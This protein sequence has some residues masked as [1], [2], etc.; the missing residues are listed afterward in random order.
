MTEETLALI[1]AIKSLES[2]VKMYGMVTTVGIS[3][4]AIQLAILSFPSGRTE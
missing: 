3:L 1:E 2:L 4:V